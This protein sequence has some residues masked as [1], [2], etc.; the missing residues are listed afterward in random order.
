MKNLWLDPQDRP[1]VI[2]HRGAKA[3][4]PE[5]TLAS[6]ALARAQG[7]EGVEFDVHLCRTGEAVI[8]HDDDVA[9]T[10]N[11]TGHVHELT[12]EQLR[13]LDAGAGQRIPTLDEVFEAERAGD[14]LF[15]VELK[16]Y[17]RKDTGLERAVV[18][19]VRRHAIGS[20]VLFSSFNPFA[21]RRL[22]AL[23]PDVPRG[24]LYAP[25]MPVYLRR[26]WL[27]PFI[28]HQARHPHFSM[29]TRELVDGLR[30][31]GL[32][33]NTWTVNKPEDMRRMR[34]C[35]VQGVIGDSPI[36]ITREYGL[37]A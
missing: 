35:G 5:N 14:F 17:T 27:A 37:A 22:A 23:M 4:A 7:A 18:E 29:V 6:F 21:V 28:P 2:G 13:A 30:A 16:G 11:G 31:R 25:S 20:R 36:A 3:H 15:N 19:I 10:T 33:V 8:I 9:R 32:L 12:L 1:L 26:L 24:M 34:D